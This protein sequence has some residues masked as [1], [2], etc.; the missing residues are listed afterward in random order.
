MIQIKKIKKLIVGNWKMNPSSLSEAKKIA[1]EIKKT[2]KN[3]TKTGIKTVRKTQVVIC[4]P[5]VYLGSVGGMKTTSFFLGAQDAFYESMGAYTGEVSY[6]SLPQ[7]GVSHVILGHSER[8][9]KGETNE[10]INKKVRSVVGEGMTA[11]VCVGESVR[12]TEGIYLHI[13]R[14]QIVAAL[15]EVNKKLLDHVV[16]AYEPIWA[17]GAKVAMNSRD[18]HEISIYIKKVLREMYGPLG[19][20]VRILY[21]G[22]V[23]STNAR[24]IVY[25]GNVGG[26]L[27]GRASL[28][29]KDFS[30]IVREIDTEDCIEK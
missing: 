6:C 18:V 30:L 1:L 13:L 4:P 24:E 29:P 3:M 2:M 23:D 14:S 25:E 17:I 12:D 5:F 22:S 15:Y 28:V 7:F 27:V 8:R 21:G 11:I 9:A 16:I 26:L 19:D 10:I 20:S